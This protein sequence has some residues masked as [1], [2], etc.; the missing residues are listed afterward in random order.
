MK[1]NSDIEVCHRK[2]QLSFDFFCSSE[3]LR[4]ILVLINTFEI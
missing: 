4:K 1:G 2:I 3:K